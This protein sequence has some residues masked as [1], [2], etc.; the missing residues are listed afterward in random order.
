MPAEHDDLIPGGDAEAQP[1][2]PQEEV[3]S[4]ADR[5]N[6]AVKQLTQDDKGVLQ[7]PKDLE[8]DDAL[9]TAVLSEKRR[10]DTESAFSKERQRAAA[11]EAEARELRNQLAQRIKVEVPPQDAARLEDLKYSDPEAWR[12][13]MNRLEQASLANLNTQFSEASRKAA[14]EIEVER[15][16]QVLDEFKAANSDFDLTDEIVSNDIPPRITKKLEQGKVSFEEFLVEVRDYL[17]HGKVI[18]DPSPV[19]TAPNLSTV[20][21]G[22]KPDANAKTED[23]I[24]SYR[25]EIY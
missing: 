12:K 19:K 8:L 9:K 6:A 20:G 21:G 17:S 7:L 11:L 14:G 10:R 5:V 25:D 1:A 18:G 23:A 24:L 2:A 22:S 13:E 4:F 3:L 16:R 15:R